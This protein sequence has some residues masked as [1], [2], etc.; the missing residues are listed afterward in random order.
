MYFCDTQKVLMKIKCKTVRICPIF[1]FNFHCFTTH[2]LNWFQIIPGLFC[3]WLKMLFMFK[4]DSKIIQIDF[5]V[6]KFTAH[7]HC[8]FSSSMSIWLRFLELKPIPNSSIWHNTRSK[9][10]EIIHLHNK[11]KTIAPAKRKR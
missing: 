7:Q 11:I 2:G 5:R 9:S 1:S 3:R 4:T 10:L 8:F 6:G